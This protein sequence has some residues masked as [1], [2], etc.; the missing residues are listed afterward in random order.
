M[1]QVRVLNRVRSYSLGSRMGVSALW[2]ERREVPLSVAAPP[3]PVHTADYVAGVACALL[4]Q[5]VEQ[6]AFNRWVPGS[7][8]GQG[9]HSPVVYVA[10]QQILVLQ[11]VVRL[12]AGERSSL[13]CIW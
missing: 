7:T 4:A 8:P 3:H 2:Y 6:P 5:L 10:A 12:H 9:T 1:V 13:W 11:V